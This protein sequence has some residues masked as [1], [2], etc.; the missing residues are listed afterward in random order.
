MRSSP[1]TSPSPRLGPT[2]SVRCGLVAVATDDGAIRLRALVEQ[3]SVPLSPPPSRCRRSVTPLV[4]MFSTANDFAQWMKLF[5]RNN[6]SVSPDRPD[7]ILD[8]TT[9]TEWCVRALADHVFHR[10]L[11]AIVPSFSHPPHTANVLPPLRPLRDPLLSPALH[12]VPV[13]CV[14]GRLN[15]RA[16][17]D[18][19][20]PDVGGLVVKEY[21]A[22]WEVFYARNNDSRFEASSGCA[23]SGGSGCPG[24]CSGLCRRVRRV[25]ARFDMTNVRPLPADVPPPPASAALS[26]AARGSHSWLVSNECL[27]VCA[28]KRALLL[29]EG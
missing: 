19:D 15:H 1:T 13:L 7:Q 3:V 23:G 8:G 25:C 9:L 21:G 29:I 26:P 11:L 14:H 18:P 28:G 20:T 22:V 4:Q 27:A 17:T 10:L 24:G 5:L 2:Q 12:R 6:V 16:I